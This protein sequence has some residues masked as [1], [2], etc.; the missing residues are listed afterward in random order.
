[1]LLC[2]EGLPEFLLKEQAGNRVPSKI[3]TCSV[4]PEH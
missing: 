4:M 2:L 1:M 3:P